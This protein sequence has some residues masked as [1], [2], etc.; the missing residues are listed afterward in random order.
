VKQSPKRVERGTLYIATTGAAV[1]VTP[2]DGKKFTYE[3]QRDAVGGYVQSMTPAK[4]GEAVWVNE[5]G[6][7]FGLAKNTRTWEFADRRTYLVLNG[8]LY[9]PDWLA[10]GNALRV[11]KV[12]ADSAEAGV[13]RLTVAQ[14]VSR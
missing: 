2:A 9:P 4:R 6:G 8:F 11:Y 7:L 3:E 12:D 14:A 10:S 5:E 1:P 13:T